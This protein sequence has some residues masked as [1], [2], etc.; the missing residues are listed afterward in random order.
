MIVAK[1]LSYSGSRYGEKKDDVKEID[2][3]LITIF[4]CLQGRVRFGAGNDG[5][6]GENIQGEWQVIADT[7]AI[8]TE[9]S[10]THGLGSVPVGYLVVKTNKGGVIYDSGTT[11]TSTTIYLKCSAAN[12]TVTLFLLQ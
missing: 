12:A 2:K 10:V 11:W 1:L 5:S 4:N 6:G 3:D 7:G 9:F 8:N